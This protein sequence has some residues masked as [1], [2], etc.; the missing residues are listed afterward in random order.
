[1]G[2]FLGFPKERVRECKIHICTLGNGIGNKTLGKGYIFFLIKLQL[3]IW[4]VIM[5]TYVENW[6]FLRVGVP[7]GDRIKAHIVGWQNESRGT[8]P[9]EQ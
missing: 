2:R 1:M 8:T 6:P 5:N 4:Y 7:Q 9:I 3:R